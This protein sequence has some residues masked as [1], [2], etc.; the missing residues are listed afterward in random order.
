M[1]RSTAI[2]IVLTACLM[3]APYTRAASIVYVTADGH[4]PDVSWQD[5]APQPIP[6]PTSLAVVLF[7]AFAAL[8]RRRRSSAIVTDSSAATVVA[9][10][11][12][13]I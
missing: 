12:Q 4:L 6:E 11:V 5:V 7:G 9:A 1:K 13:T 3:A 8:S 2:I 10:S